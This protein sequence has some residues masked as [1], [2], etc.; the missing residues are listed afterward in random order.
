MALEVHEI[1]D[2]LN[3]IR[4]CGLDYFNSLPIMDDETVGFMP[5]HRSDV[6]WVQVGDGNKD[7]CANLQLELLDPVR[8]ISNC[9]ALSALLT[10]AD[11]RDVGQWTKSIRASL[12]LRQ[13]H[14]WDTEVLHD[15]GTVLG[16]RHP[17]QSDSEP[18][19]PHDARPI[20]ERGIS[21]LLGLVDLLDVGPRH[22]TNE[23]FLNPQATVRYVPNTAFVMM[24]IDPTNP[25][26]D[27][28]Y[29]TYKECFFNFGITAIRA[30]E[31]EHQEAITDKI[32]EKIRCSEFLL[33]DLT[34]ERP[35]V[36]YEIGFAHALGRKVIMYRNS[37]T[38]LHFDFAGYNCPE[39]RNLSNLKEQLIRRL[40][41]MTNREP[42]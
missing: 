8:E 22:P 16:V 32:L 9:I 7:V 42:Q 30:D 17:G 34:A 41:H 23:T 31:I 39:Y 5:D 3:R 18:M 19:H 25:S 11:R 24:Q 38:R 37:D 1:R 12:R 4:I 13:Y 6:Y 10:E 2:A 14:N 33:A 36:Y 21:N 28:L 40:R 26:L 35:S 15:E 20:F 27:D 29:N